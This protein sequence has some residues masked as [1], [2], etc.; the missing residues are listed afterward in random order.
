M[1]PFAAIFAATVL[2]GANLAPSSAIPVM[3]PSPRLVVWTK[4]EM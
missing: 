1:Q 3:V 2:A 4:L